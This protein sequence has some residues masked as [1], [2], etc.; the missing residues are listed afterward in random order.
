MSES[1][2][3]ILSAKDNATA[4]IKN[5]SKE[6]TL[7]ADK[8]EQVGE[9]AKRGT[10]AMEKFANVLGAGWLTDGYRSFKELSDGAAGAAK[11]LKAGGSASLAMRAG[12]AGL[13]AVVSYK[14]GEVIAGWVF[15]TKKFTEEL[16]RATEQAK[17]LGNQITSKGSKQLDRDIEDLKKYGKTMRG[18]D[19]QQLQKRIHLELEGK[20]GQEAAAKAQLEALESK[21][22]YYLVSQ[23]E[24]DAAKANLEIIQQGKK[25]YQERRDQ[26]QQEF[27]EAAKFREQWIAQ[28]E[29]EKKAAEDRIKNQV[30]LKEMAMAF[31]RDVNKE[32]EKQEQEKIKA[33]EKAAKQR[34]TAEIKSASESVKALEKEISEIEKVRIDTSRPTLN[35]QDERMKSLAR[36]AGDIAKQQLE[37]TKRQVKIAELN[38]KLM[39]ENARYL[40]LL[41]EKEES[42]IAFGGAG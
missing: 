27:S 7:A 4:V 14:I 3:I 15:E 28:Q 23:E 32:F 36:G 11:S 8:I 25:V 31:M 17:E 24:V 42:V 37:Q 41:A 18:E 6:L 26:L 35:S 10:D 9:G 5:A 1:V 21:R 19:I 22:S 38:Q 40:K 39:Q 2:E 12:L 33:A 34:Q 30:K 29:A 20:A 16:L 13:T